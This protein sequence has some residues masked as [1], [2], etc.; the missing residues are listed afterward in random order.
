MSLPAFD[1]HEYVKTLA[2]KGVSAATAE[3]LAEIRSEIRV[4]ERSIEDFRK[5]V[6]LRLAEF[7]SEL[8]RW[9]FA[10]FV[11]QTGTILTLKFL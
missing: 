6:D 7:K 11:V 1:S 3:A 2:A 8:V 9:L 5:D 10:F 4:L